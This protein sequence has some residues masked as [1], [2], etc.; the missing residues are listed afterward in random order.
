MPSIDSIIGLPGVQIEEVET[1]SSIVV[2]AKTT[3]KPP[4]IYCG[5]KRS[6]IKSSFRRELK[7]TRQGNRVMILSILSHKFLCLLCRR[8]FNLRIPGVLPRKKATESFR[9]EVYERHHGGVSQRLLSRTH[10]IGEATVERWYQDF[11]VYRV[12]E[13]EGRCA[14]KVLGIDEHFF[15]RERKF[16][17]VTSG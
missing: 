3:L 2:Y 11:V 10:G 5:G 7:H 9:Q 8:Y 4:C 12:K 14:P 13:L 16:F 6:R 17:C 15:T 1:S